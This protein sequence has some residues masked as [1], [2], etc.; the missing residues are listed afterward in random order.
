MTTLYV[1]GSGSAGNAFALSAAGQSVLIDAGFSAREIVKRAERVGLAMDSLTGLILTHEHADH[2]TGAERIARTLG[3]PI[4]A[5]LGTWDRLRPRMPRAR[6]TP[7]VLLGE[8]THGGF[9]IQACPTSHDAAEPIALRILSPAGHW[10]AVAYDLGRPTAGVRFLLRDANLI[11]LEANHDELLLRT[12][13]Y[14]PSVQERIAGS[15][16]HL[17][18]RVAAELLREATHPALRAVVLAH[19]SERCNSAS[20]ATEE[21]LPV[22][23]PHGVVLHVAG[24]HEPLRPIALD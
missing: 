5:S 11:I 21:I 4:L 23:A 10:I 3:I 1:L 6:F 20:R 13:G 7:L 24:Q 17:S 18:N 12:S 19:L 8:T 9:R 14:P 22:L 2:A 15:G 16:G